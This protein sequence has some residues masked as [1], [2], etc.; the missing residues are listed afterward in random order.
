MTS[1]GPRPGSGSG[2]PSTWPPPRLVREHQ[3]PG[4]R[5]QDNGLDGKIAASEGLNLAVDFLPGS[6]DFGPLGWTADEGFASELLWF[7]ALILNVDYSQVRY[8][9]YNLLVVDCAPAP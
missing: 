7:D 1:A 3:R 6:A 2:S 5:D 9:G 8:T 4:D